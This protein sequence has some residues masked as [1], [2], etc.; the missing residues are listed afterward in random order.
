MLVLG[1]IAADR[2][3]PSGGCVA[4]IAIGAG[5]ERF[6]RIIENQGGDPRVV[7]DYSRLPA[8]ARTRIW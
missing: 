8:G 1:G 3:T 6:R 4:A 5:L 7:D 2:P